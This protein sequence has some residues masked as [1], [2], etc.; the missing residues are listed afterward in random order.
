MPSFSALERVHSATAPAALALALLVGSVGFT[1]AAAAEGEP[2]PA[3]TTPPAETTPAAAPAVEAPAAD[4]AP[5]PPIVSAS[6]DI[7][8]GPEQTPTGGRT[9]ALGPSLRFVSSGHR[10]YAA[11]M[12]SLNAK[13]DV[14]GAATLK[15]WVILPKSAAK[16]AD[17][18]RHDVTLARLSQRQPPSGRVTLKFR[19]DG[20]AQE[21]LLRFYKV[22]VTVRLAATDAAGHV[23]TVDQA[24]SLAD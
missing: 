20:P 4:L 13:V 22:T 21:T 16:A 19:F 11:R 9:G 23:R 6:V 2:V 8:P 1:S 3:A 5:A 7:L 15:A 17:A 14:A 24:V 18:A 12:K 10:L